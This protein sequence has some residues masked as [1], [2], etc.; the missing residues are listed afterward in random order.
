LTLSLASANL[1]GVK[2]THISLKPTKV[3]G[4]PFW[5]LT[6]PKP[7]GGRIRRTFKEKGIAQQ[8]FSIA[9]RE[10][11]RSGVDAA[12]MPSLLR[13]QAIEAERILK[14]YGLSVLDAAKAYVANQESV[15]LSCTVANAVRDFLE[16]KVAAGVSKRYQGDL[17]VRLSR[18]SAAFS[19]RRMSEVKPEAISEWLNSLGTS[20]VDRNNTRRLVFG[21]FAF[22]VGRGWNG[23]NP[24]ESV[25]IAKDL[26]HTYLSS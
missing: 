8:A 26:C 16:D 2:A 14:P 20:A 24:V 3:N 23:K 19:D 1:H 5:Q 11:S 10:M 4:I 17:R 7:G 6:I 9:Q 25:S 15:N 13:E 22:G 12:A 18:F 21:L